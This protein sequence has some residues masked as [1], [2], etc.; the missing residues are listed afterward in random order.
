MSGS[1]PCCFLW[2][3]PVNTGKHWWWDALLESG[4]FTYSRFVR[5]DFFFCCVLNMKVPTFLHNTQVTL[6]E[7]WQQ[8]PVT[9]T[10]R[11]FQ[12]M[13][14]TSVL[15]RRWNGLY[16]FRCLFPCD[17][18]S[19]CS[20]E[21]PCDPQKSRGG[22]KS[23]WGFYLLLQLACLIQN[24]GWTVC[25]DSIKHNICRDVLWTRE[26]NARLNE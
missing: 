14:M 8:N 23:N 5:A 25:W 21:P 26:W 7:V 1:K 17:K 22:I 24:A 4:N 19:T 13:A 6:L 15:T 2:A 10:S 16:H 12:V 20:R 3:T 18:P 11:Y 9:C